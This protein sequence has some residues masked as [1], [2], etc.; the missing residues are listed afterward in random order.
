ML[1]THPAAPHNTFFCRR[2]DVEYAAFVH[3]GAVE[4]GGEGKE[5]S[6]GGAGETAAKKPR[7]SLLSCSPTATQSA[8]W[9]GR[10]LPSATVENYVRYF[11]VKH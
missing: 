7:L 4:G 6:G 3:L 2:I 10:R 5:G 8:D 9:T 1:A 11:L